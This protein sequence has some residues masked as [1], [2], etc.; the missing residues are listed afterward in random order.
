MFSTLKLYIISII[1]Y[2]IYILCLSAYFAININC[3]HILLILSSPLSMHST[4]Q[5]FNYSPCLSFSL[6]LSPSGSTYLLPAVALTFS[7]SLICLLSSVHCSL[8]TVHCRLHCPARVNL[9]SMTFALPEFRSHSALV[10]WGR[11]H[12]TVIVNCNYT[13]SS[14]PPP[15]PL[16]LPSCSTAHHAVKCQ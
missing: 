4:W 9:L 16:P 6:T 1:L 10:C 3:K 7:I 8:S 2:T 15:S 12:F 5:S 14:S 13:A 11:K